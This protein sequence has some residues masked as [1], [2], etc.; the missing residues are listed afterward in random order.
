MMMTTMII[1]VTIRKIVIVYDVGN[2]K[3]GNIML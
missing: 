2:D 1:N 3:L